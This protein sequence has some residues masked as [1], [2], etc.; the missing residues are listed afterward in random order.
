MENGG[1]PQEPQES[2]ILDNEASVARLA[3]IAASYAGSRVND[4]Y[5]GKNGQAPEVRYSGRFR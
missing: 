5:I 4:V 2:F 3:E 1:T